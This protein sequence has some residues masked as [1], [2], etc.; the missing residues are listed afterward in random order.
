MRTFATP[1]VHR[2]VGRHL[3]VAACLLAILA[4]PAAAQLRGTLTEGGVPGPVAMRGAVSTDDP[5]RAQFAAPAYRVHPPE[6]SPPPG[7]APG[8]TRRTIQAFGAWTLICDENLRRRR[9]VCNASQSIVD[10]DGAFAFSWSLA[11]T[12]EGAPVFVV[13]APV[14]A[15][16]AH[17][18]GLAF[19]T[20]EETVIRLESCN[21]SLCLGFLPVSEAV[22]R[23][24]A[25]R[26]A[27][28]IRY[29]RSDGAA[30]AAI[31][32]SLDGLGTAIASIK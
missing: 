18:V 27:V 31:A 19:G 24:I 7:E 6:G 29:R 21:A 26:A 5:P 12:S 16:S 13:R 1:A 4:V 17:T 15:W 28:R 14:G 32:T 10:G 8:D 20:A 23:A 3:A 9:R 25:E 11:A 22:R 30:P 2:T